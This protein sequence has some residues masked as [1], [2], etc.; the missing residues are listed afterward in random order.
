MRV[1]RLPPRT[2]QVPLAL[3]NLSLMKSPD[4]SVNE[5]DDGGPVDDDTMGKVVLA[6][7]KCELDLLGD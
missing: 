3:Q 7:Q 2:V 4:G 1:A 6:K 5:D